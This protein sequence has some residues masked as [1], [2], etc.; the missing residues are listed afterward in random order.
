MGEA[1]TDRDLVSLFIKA[2]RRLGDAGQPQEAARLGAQ[3]W[4]LL[5]NDD[6]Q[7]AE[8]VNGVMH[9]LARLEAQAEA[10]PTTADAADP[11]LSPVPDATPPAAL[12]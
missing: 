4:W 2:L 3:A 12:A 6:P 11:A 5:K 10:R 7:A 8:H 1:R 9:Y